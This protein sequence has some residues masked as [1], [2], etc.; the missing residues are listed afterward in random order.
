MSK[1]SE[2]GLRTFLPEFLQRRRYDDEQ[3][4]RVDGGYRLAKQQ[5][6]QSF[7]GLRSRKVLS[8]QHKA[9]AGVQRAVDRR[10]D[11]VRVGNRPVAQSCSSLELPVFESR[12]ASQGRNARER[13][14]EA[15]RQT[16]Y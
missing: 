1:A 4:G 13:L 14:V 5:R 10:R 15:L 6:Q 2:K 11:D 9:S 8:N 12:V 3:G 16:E 7:R